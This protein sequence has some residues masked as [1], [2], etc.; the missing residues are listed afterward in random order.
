MIFPV[1]SVSRPALGSTQPPDRWVPWV[2]FPG[3]KRNRV[4]TLTTH[5]HLVPRSWMSRSYIFSP[6]SV[7]M[8][9][10]AL[11]LKTEQRSY[12]FLISYTRNEDKDI[13]VSVTERKDNKTVVLMGCYTVYFWLYANFSDKYFASILRVELRRIRKVMSYRL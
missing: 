9:E 3:L 4:V 7:F 10:T 8:A 11:G 12:P 6:P 1:F 5:P 13:W 2:L